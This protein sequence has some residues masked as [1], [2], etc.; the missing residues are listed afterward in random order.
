MTLKRQHLVCPLV[1]DFPV[2]KRTYFGRIYQVEIDLTHVNNPSR[3]N[4]YLLVSKERYP[5]YADNPIEGD[6]ILH[7]VMICI[8]MPT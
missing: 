1:K 7:P 3:I 5:Q 2:H 8:S 6:A 4:T